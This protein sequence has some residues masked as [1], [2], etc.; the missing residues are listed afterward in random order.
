MEALNN[1]KDLT[2]G[3]Y[4]ARWQK[5]FLFN[6]YIKLNELHSPIIR[7][8]LAEWVKIHDLTVCFLRETHFNYK[9]KNMLKMKRWKKDVPRKQ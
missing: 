3:K 9:D 2:Y 4:I 7:Q 1:K 8:R 6:T 5:S